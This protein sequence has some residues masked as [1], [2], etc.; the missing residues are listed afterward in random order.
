MSTE[1]V[2]VPEDSLFRIEQSTHRPGLHLYGS[3]DGDARSILEREL[4]KALRDGRD[5]HVDLS[6][7]DFISVGCMQTLMDAATYLHLDG[8]RLVLLGPN[9]AVR[10]TMAICQETGPGNVQVLPCPT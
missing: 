5:L 1:D 8:C 10:L 3:L 4:D 7:L 9:L 2:L 6:N